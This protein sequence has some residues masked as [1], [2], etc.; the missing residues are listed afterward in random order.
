MKALD[1]CLSAALLEYVLTLH[2]NTE[3]AFAS[4]LS[5]G[6][7]VKTRL[8][9]RSYEANNTILPQKRPPTLSLLYA[10]T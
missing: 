8:H 1:N 9:A 2:T 3:A 7:F 10:P 6:Y 4:A 5:Q